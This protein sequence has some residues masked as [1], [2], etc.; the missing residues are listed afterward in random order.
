LLLRKD[1]DALVVDS[2]LEVAAKE[3]GYKDA[4]E[5]KKK[6]DIKQ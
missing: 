4:A 2:Y 6:L 3:L 5:L 1:L